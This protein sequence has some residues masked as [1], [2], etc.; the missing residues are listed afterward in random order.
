MNESPDH[1]RAV[2]NAA[3]GIVIGVFAAVALDLG[4]YAFGTFLTLLSLA[5]FANV[6]IHC[7]HEVKQ[8]RR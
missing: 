2:S 7:W 6:A 5:C 8:E 3:K 4:A 1:K